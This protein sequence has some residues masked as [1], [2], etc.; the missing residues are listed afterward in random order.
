MFEFHIVLLSQST[1]HQQFLC[2]WENL[3]R[4]AFAKED[5]NS[6]F[7]P[8]MNC[9]RRSRSHNSLTA[10][11]IL[12]S[13]SLL[14]MEFFSTPLQCRTTQ[15]SRERREGSHFYFQPQLKGATTR[16]RYVLSRYSRGPIIVSGYLSLYV[17]S[18]GR[19]GMGTNRYSDLS[20][21][22]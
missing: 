3:P 18:E 20:Q 16:A 19:N 14:L 13:S 21:G 5:K 1:P 11:T 22:F 9:K 8:P 4:A 2:W 17:L 15:I 6:L 7:S 10:L 12:F